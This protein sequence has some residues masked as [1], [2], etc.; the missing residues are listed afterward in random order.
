ML[1]AESDWTG[2]VLIAGGSAGAASDEE[3]DL[4]DAAARDRVGRGIVVL[5]LLESLACV[6]IITNNVG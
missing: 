5:A 1:S 4:R 3:S 2:A 6:C